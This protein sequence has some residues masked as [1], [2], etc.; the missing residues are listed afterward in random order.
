MMGPFCLVRARGRH[1]GPGVL[2]PG[3][4]RSTPR[5]I[6]RTRIWSWRLGPPN[7]NCVRLWER[8]WERPWLHRGRPTDGDTVWLIGV[9]GVRF[10]STK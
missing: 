9:W 7:P 8:P 10:I 3:P 1:R 5:R 6:G 2:N 4:G